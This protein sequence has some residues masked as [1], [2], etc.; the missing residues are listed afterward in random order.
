V[1]RTTNVPEGIDLV[2]GEAERRL[3]AQLRQADALDT[4]AGVLVG[5]HALAAG[6]L[7]SVASRI[8]GEARRAAAVTILG[9]LISGWFSL[10]A[11]RAQAYDRGPRPEA[12]WRFAAWPVDEIQLRFLSARFNAISEN[13]EKLRAKARSLTASLVILGVLAFGVG[14][15]SIVGLLR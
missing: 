6:L 15:A 2:W 4:K 1:D 12:M 9:L 10:R 7:A 11:F 3:E 14:V 13:R 5:I 8:V